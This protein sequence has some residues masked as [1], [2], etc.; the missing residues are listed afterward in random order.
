MINRYILL[1][2]V[3]VGLGTA[4]AYA[5]LAEDTDTQKNTATAQ[6]QADAAV[7]PGANQGYG[8]YIDPATGKRTTPPQSTVIPTA[9]R[10]VAVTPQAKVINLGAGKGIAVDMRGHYQEVKA[11]V[12]QQGHAST[13]CEPTLNTPVEQPAWGGMQ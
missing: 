11:K 13:R 7:S 10:A 2:T 3:F 1:T 5:G 8:V 9:P 12:D 6:V 4:G